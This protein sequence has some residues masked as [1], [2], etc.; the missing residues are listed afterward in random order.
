MTATQHIK[1]DKIYTSE[2]KLL[3]NYEI[4]RLKN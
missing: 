1:T 2:Y 4:N 3:D